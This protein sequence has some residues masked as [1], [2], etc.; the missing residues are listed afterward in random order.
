MT[1]SRLVTL[2][3]PGGVGKTRIAYELAERSRRAFR[4]GSWVVELASVEDE[5]GLASIVVSSLAVA[6]QSNRAP[7]RKLVDHLRERQLLIVLDNCE[8][9]LAPVANLVD[10]MLAESP[11]LRILATSREP[12]GIARRAHLHRSA[13]DDSA[14]GRRADAGAGR[15]IR[16]GALAGRPRPRD[17]SRFRCDTGE[18]R[19]RGAAVQPARWHPAGHR[20]RRHPAARP[21]AHPDRG[22]VG[23]AIF[24]V[25]RRKPDGHAPPADPARAHRLELRTLRRVRKAALGKA[26]SVHRQLRPGCRG[27]GVRLR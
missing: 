4:D 5:S 26:F 8:H 14:Q 2:T 9:L 19:C 7:I 12:L 3:G 20:T 24:A 1:E 22:S 11:G 21:V 17:Q 25:D 13:S 6:D 18:L 10:A 16:G 15:P 27:T 23:Q